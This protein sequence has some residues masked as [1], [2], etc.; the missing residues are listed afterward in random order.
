MQFNQNESVFT[1]DGKDAGHIDRVVIDPQTNEVTHLVVRKGF[2]F[3]SDKVVPVEHVMPGPQGQI[4][5][6]L[7]SRQLAELPDFAE[8]QYVTIEEGKGNGSPTTVFAYPPYPGGAP[9]Q[10]NFGPRVVRETHLN[11]P[12]D[13]VALREGAKVVSRDD[14]DVGHVE[15]VLTSPPGD[16]V[17]HF[18]ISRGLLVKEKRL[19]P[20]GWVER[21]EEGE[22]RLAVESSTVEKLPIVEPA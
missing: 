10:S 20:V 11:I 13:T 9:L 8:T 15:Q 2:L 14:T 12:D 18:L 19:I 4:A 3:T 7:D 22:V 17:T 16:Q 6:Q 1:A 21:L 5:L